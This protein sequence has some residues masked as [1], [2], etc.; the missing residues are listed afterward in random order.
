MFPTRVRDPLKMV[1]RRVD[2]E[3]KLRAYRVWTFWADELGE[4]IAARAQP[5]GLRAGV[6]TV[7]V[8]NHAWMQ[9]LQFMRDEIV[10]RLNARLGQP[11]IKDIFLISGTKEEEKPAAQSRM[12]GTPEP[13]HSSVAIPPLRDARLSAVFE[14]LAEA[15]ARRRR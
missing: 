6:L 7:A 13:A 2:P 15:Q 12:F 3:Q 10:G 9:E 1:L 5:V 4:A 11:L 8:N 14:R